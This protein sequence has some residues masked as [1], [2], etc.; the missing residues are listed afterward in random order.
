MDALEERQGLP[1]KVSVNKAF[2]KLK[3]EEGIRSRYERKGLEYQF[4]EG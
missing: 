4:G 3:T 1:G 2:A